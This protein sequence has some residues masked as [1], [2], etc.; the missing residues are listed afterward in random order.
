[1]IYADKR[2]E[3]KRAIKKIKDTRAMKAIRKV[4]DTKTF[5]KIGEALK[6]L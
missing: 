5:K 3:I 6:Q 1:M 4:K 2:E